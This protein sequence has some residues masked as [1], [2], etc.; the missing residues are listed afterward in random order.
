VQPGQLYGNPFQEVIRAVARRVGLRFV[1][2]VVLDPGGNI[3]DV[4]AG[5]PFLVHPYLIFSASSLYNRILE[6]T[7]DV[8]VAGVD[9]P[10]DASLFQAILAAMFVGLA[11]NAAVRPDGVILLPAATPEAI[12]SGTNA[13]NFYSALQGVRSLDTL[14]AELLE[15]GYRPGEA[16][17]FQLAR[18]LEQNKVVVVGS[19]FPE[20]VEACHMYAATTME[21]A[22]ELTRW[23]LGDD[24]EALIIPHALYTLPVHPIADPREWQGLAVSDEQIY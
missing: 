5:D 4:Q 20:M 2:N 19:E 16:R 23:W 15:H 9:P 21:E 13:Q 24:V 7:Y 12:G 10:H 3:V 14:V 22:V 8:V 17:A 11:P 18:L 6:R 1:L